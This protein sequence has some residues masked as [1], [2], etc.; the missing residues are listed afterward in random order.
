MKRGSN[1]NIFMALQMT[2]GRFIN[3]STPLSDHL[4]KQ[5]TRNASLVPDVM[6][7]D[8]AGVTGILLA[9]E[10]G[11]PL[12]VNNPG[13]MLFNSKVVD[14]LYAPAPFAQ[15]PV[16]MGLVERMKNILFAI[17]YNAFDIFMGYG[18]DELMLASD[19][20][21][22]RRWSLGSFVDTA[23]AILCNT[24]I[25]LDYARPVDPR[26]ILTGPMN[27]I[28]SNELSEDLSQWID[29]QNEVIYVSFGTMVVLTREQVFNISAALDRL[30][31]ATVWSLAKD[32]RQFLG[33]SQDDMPANVRLETYV[34]QPQLLRHP[35]LRLFH[36]HGGANSAHDVLAAGKPVVCTPVF[37]DQPEVCQ[38]MV[39]HGFGVRVLLEDLQSDKVY[40]AIHQVLRDSSF[41]AR[42]QQL[43]K[44]IGRSKGAV[45]GADTVLMAALGE[46]DH[47]K[48]PQ[49]PFYQNYNLDYLA[50]FAVAVVVWWCLAQC[51]LRCCWRCCSSR[52]AQKLK[53]E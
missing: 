23:E 37:G 11:I 45:L 33:V 22:Q 7:V 48:R 3:A 5:W 10:F 47:L 30:G 8:F 44:V 28:S 46:L 29:A 35:K 41:E 27:R 13:M 1:K 42:T 26:I 20:T 38:R 6:V 16:E 4:R 21:A 14:A 34:A 17:G 32:Q 12:V 15:I 53:S 31:V 49:R 52:S 18:L 36:T 25:G 50:A 40:N 43:S 19:P 2:A 51:C 39:S 24:V 9:H